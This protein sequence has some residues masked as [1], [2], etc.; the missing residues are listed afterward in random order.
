MEPPPPSHHA[1]HTLPG[2]E[3]LHICDDPVEESLPRFAGAPG[4]VGGDEEIVEAGGAGD[5]EGVVGGGRFALKRVR[6]CT[7]QGCAL[8][9]PAGRGDKHPLRVERERTRIAP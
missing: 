2:A 8:A 4:G 1:I 7:Q 6:C 3:S 9:P 5:E